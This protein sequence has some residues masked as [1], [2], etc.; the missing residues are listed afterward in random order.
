LAKEDAE[1]QAAAATSAQER[2]EKAEAQAV[3]ERDR[4]AKAET[5]ALQAQARAEKAELAARDLAARLD[6]Q[7]TIS[8]DVQGVG[9]E[10]APD[11]PT[12]PDRKSPAPAISL[13]DLASI[14]P[15]SNE[16]ARAAFLEPLN[17]AMAEFGIDTRARQAYFL[18]QIDH[19][20]ASLRFVTEVWG[21][22]ASQLRYEPPGVIASTLG[23]TEP[24]DGRKYRGRGLLAIAGRANYKRFGDALGVD[25]VGEPDLAARPDIA[26]RVAAMFWSVKG[27]N[28]LADRDSP[29]VVREITRRING[30]VNGLESREQS[31]ARA[32][33]TLGVSR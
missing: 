9:R 22:T 23:N 14:M 17:K 29:D 27:L 32:R 19:E 28:D 33:Q 7:L 15:G 10:A 12:V 4:A 6:A 26:S 1:R 8:K 16:R 31:I 5:D 21:P 20:T 30:G 13:S 18:G 25:L 2:A 24:G 3:T 11:V